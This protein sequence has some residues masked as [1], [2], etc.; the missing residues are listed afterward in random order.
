MHLDMS[1]I[2]LY[3]FVQP[4]PCS[5]FRSSGPRNSQPWLVGTMCKQFVG[6]LTQIENGGAGFPPRLAKNVSLRF[7]CQYGLPPGTVL[8]FLHLFK[9]WMSTAPGSPRRS[10][11]VQRPVR[12]H[13]QRNQP[14]P[15]PVRENYPMSFGVHLVWR[16][17]N[18]SFFPG[19][20]Q[21]SFI[22]SIAWIG[23]PGPPT[24]S[25]CT[26]DCPPH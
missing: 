2:R 10:R 4:S 24:A 12:I 16:T 6:L 23:R 8:N 19:S 20:R 3:S 25:R 15:F 9:C 11:F 21:P 17:S 7:R 13:R 26:S 14:R 1:P 22:S 18:I 5:L